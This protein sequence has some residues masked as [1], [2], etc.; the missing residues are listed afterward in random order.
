MATI[1]AFEKIYEF[2]LANPYIFDFIIYF[3][4][5]Y[6]GLSS[7]KAESGIFKKLD[8]KANKFKIAISGILS[9]A[10]VG[11]QYAQGTNVMDVAGILIILLGLVSWYKLWQGLRTIDTAASSD[12]EESLFMKTFTA[13][14]SALVI[15]SIMKKLFGTEIFADA[16][17]EL[18]NDI[19]ELT[20]AWI[21][22]LLA[23]S[24]VFM[25]VSLV[26]GLAGRGSAAAAT[27]RG[28][29]AVNRENERLR[30]ALGTQQR[31]VETRRRQLEEQQRRQIAIRDATNRAIAAIRGDLA[32]VQQI[33]NGLNGIVRA[34]ERGAPVAPLRE[35]RYLT[36]A[37]N[38]L[39]TILTN[40]NNNIDNTVR[41][42]ARR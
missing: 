3:V 33:R 35:Q 30:E 7:E 23:I 38:R 21:Y 6:L 13:I 14:L 5:I 10:I 18:F 26:R 1:A 11:V 40:I 20:G 34:R 28:A 8:K 16:F 27:S 19:F 41:A 24:F 31:E 22:I 42:M 12:S 4:L 29:A 9:F 36:Q 25:T 17:S 32:A 15:L 37:R 39:E 2:Y